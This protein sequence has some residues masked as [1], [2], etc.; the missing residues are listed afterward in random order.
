MSDELF[1]PRPGGLVDSARHGSTQEQPQETAT[2]T[3]GPRPYTAVRVRP[4]PPDIAAARTITLSAANQVLPILGQD[5][6]R[7]SAVLLAVDNAVYLATDLGLAQQVAGGSTAEG[8]FYLPAGIAI[9]V[10]TQGQ[11]WVACTTV[12]TSSRVSVLVTKDSAP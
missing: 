6:Q 7:R 8:A 2:V 3:D 9:P 12:A 4:E 10:D 5:G 1:P 11:V